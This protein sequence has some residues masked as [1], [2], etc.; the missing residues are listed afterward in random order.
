MKYSFLFLCA[1]CIGCSAARAEVFFTLGGFNGYHG[2]GGVPPDAFNKLGEVQKGNKVELKCIAFTPGGDWVI[3]FG[4]NGIW[5]NNGNLPIIK[6]LGELQKDPN[7][8]VRSVAFAPNGAFTIMDGGGFWADGGTPEDAFNKM[9]EIGK[10][11]GKLRSIAYAPSGGWVILFDKHGVIYRGIPKDLKEVLDE[12]VK[13]R[14][15]VQCVAFTIFGDWICLTNHGWW[16]S[17]LD[18]DASKS[19]AA[20]PNDSPKWLAFVPP[21]DD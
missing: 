16:T 19:L 14:V 9:S 20:H 15:T 17:N 11:G 10:H 8:H 6:K 4:G 13:N 3:L 5:T 12:A 1:V 21:V 2:S 18:L 7:S